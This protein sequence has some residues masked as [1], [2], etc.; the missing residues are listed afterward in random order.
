MSQLQ[1]DPA[2]ATRSIRSFRGTVRKLQALMRL[3]LR[4][5]CQGVTLA[6]CHVLLAVDARAETT[7]GALAAEL[8]LDKSTLSRTVDALVEKGLVRRLPDETDRRVTLLR[9]TREG[10]AIC[11]ALHVANDQQYRRIFERI[12]Q[13]SRETVMKH[14]SL[15]V[16]AFAEHV[17][18]TAAAGNTQAERNGRR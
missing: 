4:T 15:F 2:L 14:F 5:C 9:L 11:Q 3:Q 16:R 17:E 18:E 8:Y 12:P 6:Q 7:T 1:N 13:R 10:R